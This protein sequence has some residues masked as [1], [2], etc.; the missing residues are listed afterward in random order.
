MKL[1]LLITLSLFSLNVLAE[2]IY[3]VNPNEPK[4]SYTLKST[5]YVNYDLVVTKR[6]LVPM[7]CNSRWGCDYVDEVIYT[8]RLTFIDVQ[9]TGVFESKRTNI[10]MEDMDAVSYTYTAKNSSGVFV[11]KSAILKCQ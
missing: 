11:Q 1:F 3:C 6:V 8:D 5:D 10:T 4:L 2:D 7:S 9:G